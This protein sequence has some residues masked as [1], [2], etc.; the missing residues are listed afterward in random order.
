MS[1]FNKSIHAY[2]EYSFISLLKARIKY[3]KAV[4]L[5]SGADVPSILTSAAARVGRGGGEAE[6]GDEAI[7]GAKTI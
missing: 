5:G 6:A 2:T 3:I 1:V 4:G 7:A